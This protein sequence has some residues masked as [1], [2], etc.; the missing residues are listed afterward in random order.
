[1]CTAECYQSKYNGGLKSNVVRDL[2]EIA[3]QKR[4]GQEK[5]QGGD[6]QGRSLRGSFRYRSHPCPHSSL[7]RLRY[8]L[9]LP[10]TNPT[11]PAVQPPPTY[12]EN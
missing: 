5:K 10:R 9:D 7:L 3:K 4:Y 8:N 12:T 6:V 2:S 1:M 11:H